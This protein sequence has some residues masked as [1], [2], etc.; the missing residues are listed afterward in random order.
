MFEPARPDAPE[1]IRRLAWV[2][3]VTP[4]GALASRLRSIELY[5]D[6]G[7]GRLLGGDLLE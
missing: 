7:D 4:I 6:A 3:R 5:L 2:A 1:P